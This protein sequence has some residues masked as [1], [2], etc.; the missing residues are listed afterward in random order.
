MTTELFGC[1]KLTLMLDTYDAPPGGFLQPKAGVALA[2][3]AMT[4]LRMRSCNAG[5]DVKSDVG[6]SL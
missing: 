5:E 2:D 3:S 1:T 4:V 6:A